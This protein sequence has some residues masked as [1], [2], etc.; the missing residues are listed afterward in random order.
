MSSS[1][2][3]TCAKKRRRTRPMFSCNWPSNSPEKASVRHC[4]FASDHFPSSAACP[5][6]IEVTLVSVFN[7]TLPVHIED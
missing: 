4:G 2:C 7:D 6:N 1:M 5:E 3:K